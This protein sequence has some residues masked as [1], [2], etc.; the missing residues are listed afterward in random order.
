MAGDQVL[1]LWAWI[2]FDPT[3]GN[4]GIIGI[5]EPMIGSVPL[6]GA[7]RA[8]IE[9]YRG[10]AQGTADLMKRKVELRKFSTMTVVETLEPRGE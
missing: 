3:D 7:D 2:A 1:E 9:A 4:E 10:Y 6:I 8:R 5:R